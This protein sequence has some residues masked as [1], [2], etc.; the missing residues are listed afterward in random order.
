MNCC[1]WLLTLPNRVGEPSSTTSAHTRSSGVARGSSRSAA[2]CAAQSGLVAMA[3]SGA[4]SV[5]CRR[6][7]SAP[8]ADAACSRRSAIACSVPVD[9]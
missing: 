5:T 9:E 4:I 2:T 1:S 6:L 7:T 3:S 8:A